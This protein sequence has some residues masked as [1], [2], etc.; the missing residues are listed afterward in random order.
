MY[1]EYS[2]SIHVPALFRVTAQDGEG[3]HQHPEAS[4]NMGF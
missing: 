2:K 3:N 1:E 4:R